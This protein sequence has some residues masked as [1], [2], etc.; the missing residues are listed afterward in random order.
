MVSQSAE[1]DHLGIRFK[2][3][4]VAEK[5]EYGSSAKELQYEAV[6]GTHGNRS[7]G[8]PYCCLWRESGCD[9]GPFG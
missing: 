5:F 2:R 7:T 8:R 6:R 3:I 1:N 9:F 4:H